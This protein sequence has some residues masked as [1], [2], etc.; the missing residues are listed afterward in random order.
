M[1][2]IVLATV[3]AKYI[4]AAFG[5]RYLRANLGS[6]R[7]QSKIMEFGPQLRANDIVESLLLENPRVIGLGVYIWNAS[8]MT[9]I[10]RTLR[11]VAPHVKVV[12]GGPEVSY[13][14]QSQELTALADYVVIGEGEL[15]FRRIV[16]G[17]LDGRPSLTKVHQNPVDDLDV[18]EFPYSE[19]T[20][21]DIAR[22]VVYVE[23]SRGCPFRCSFCLSSLDKSVRPFAPDAFLAQLK[24][25][26]DRG[27]RRF[28]FVD[29]TFNLSIE[30]S[31]AILDFFLEHFVE[32]L[33]LHFEMIP[34]RLPDGLRDRITRFPPGC[35][36]FEVGIQSFNSEVN[37]RIQRRQDLTRVE[38]NLAFLRNHTGVHV[39]ADLIIGLPGE[40]WESFCDGLDRLVHM[41]PQEIQVGVLKRL[42]GTPLTQIT[43]EYEMQ[44]DTSPPY[45][46]LSSAAMSF[47]QLQSAKRMALLWDRIVNQGHFPRTLAQVLWADASSPSR[48][49]DAFAKW[50]HA[51]EGRVHGW[52]LDKLSL[53]LFRF[54][55]DIL[56]VDI[57]TIASVLEADLRAGGQRVSRAILDRDL[58]CVPDSRPNPAKGPPPRQRRHLEQSLGDNS[59][60]A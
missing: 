53:F 43:G 44:F 22:R 45:E 46:I 35:L 15:A 13:E 55:V 16:D 51:R 11:K 50:L 23:A 14:T 25:L 12:L 40:S 47:P 32:G 42:R 41:G 21:E 56:S 27:V 30:K 24:T 7:D 18:L 3:N 54:S 4:H 8:V 19:Y 59:I 10:C 33:F 9:E 48:R 52:S 2:E 37:A 26:L 60:S 49:M 1:A 6:R 34:D 28:K 57:E 5:L 20:D 36:Q 58:S 17:I 38:N 39:H 29:R 31:A